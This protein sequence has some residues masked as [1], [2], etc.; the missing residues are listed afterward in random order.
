M[1]IVTRQGPS[2]GVARLNLSGNESVRVEA[3]AMMAMSAGVNLEAKAEGGIFK[4]L[5]RAALG[6]ESFFLT[7]YHAPSQGGWVDIAARL[8]GDLVNVTISS[9]ESWVISKGSWLASP[10]TVEL[11]TKWGGF[12]NLFGSEGG[13]VVRA[14]GQGPIVLGCYGALD[15]WT[16]ERGETITVD[17]GHMVAYQDTVQMALRKVT[18]GL[19]QTFKSGEGLVF[20]FTGP[21][22]VYTQTRNPTELLSWL[23][24]AIG[25][26]N[27]GSPAVSGIEGVLGG[28]FG[29]D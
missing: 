8:P 11:D 28:L 5:K 29:R 20:D 26:S 7:T 18:G 13:F 22:V 27:S 24:S 21:G 15:K 17:T 6:G 4:S 14:S 3:G 2:F 12:R 16:L 1:E 19:V 9:G 25:T 10:A 23:G